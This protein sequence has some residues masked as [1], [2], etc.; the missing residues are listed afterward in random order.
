[1]EHGCK[2]YTE[3]VPKRLQFHEAPAMPALK[4]HHFGGYS[5][6]RYKKLATH[7]RTTCERSESAQESGEQRYT[8]DHQSINNY[9]TLSKPHERL[10]LAIQNIKTIQK[11]V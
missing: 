5:K 10:G 3:L 7:R 1:M 2:V 11:V 9:S 4:V 6:T 8:S